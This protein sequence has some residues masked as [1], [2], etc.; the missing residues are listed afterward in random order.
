MPAKKLTASSL[1]TG[2]GIRRGGQL[3]ESIHTALAEGAAR[4]LADVGYGEF[5]PEAVA[6]A[7][8]TREQQTECER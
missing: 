4:E 3:Y 2:Q 6:A 5:T 7:L 8:Q 1:R